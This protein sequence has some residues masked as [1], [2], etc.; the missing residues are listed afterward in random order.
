MNSNVKDY[1]NKILH[2]VNK[3][4]LNICFYLSFSLIN[5]VFLSI[6]LGEESR[7]GQPCYVN[8]INPDLNGD[9]IYS[10]NPNMSNNN[11]IINNMNNINNDGND[12]SDLF[13][14]NKCDCYM[15]KGEKDDHMYS[16]QIQNHGRQS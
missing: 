3:E 6:I 13:Y 4:K 2:K 11:T 1:P 14:C 16:H 8:R 10:V 9:G 12:I 7:N 5:S 15:I